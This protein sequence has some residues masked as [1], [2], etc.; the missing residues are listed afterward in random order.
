[1]NVGTLRRACLVCVLV[2]VMT[3]RLPAPIAEE[4]PTP[5]AEQPTKPKAKHKDASKSSENTA[6]SRAPSPT[7]TPALQRNPFDG[8]WIGTLNGGG[9]DVK[10]TLTISAGGTIVNVRSIPWG[11][12]QG[13]DVT[14]DGKTIRWRTGA[15]WTLTPNSDGKT[16]LLTASKSGFFGIGASNLSTTFQKTSP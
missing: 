2:L 1:M 12:V 11:L 3:H 8:T 7:S 5:A 14:S 16:G 6:K 10:F 15:N 4:S 9:G 13:L